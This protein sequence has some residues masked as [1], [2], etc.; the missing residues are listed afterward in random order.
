MKIFELLEPT[1][2]P[3]IE[4]ATRD[5][6]PHGPEENPDMEFPHLP[7]DSFKEKMKKLGWTFL[8]SGYFSSVFINPDKSYVI[9]MNN[10]QDR[11][12]AKFVKII[13]RN[14]NKHFPKISVLKS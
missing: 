2:E 13:K 14:P 12:F 4:Q 6:I 3:E 9:K 5:Y 8:S 1:I 7:F 11:G 10:K